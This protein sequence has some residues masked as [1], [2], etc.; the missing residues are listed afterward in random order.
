MDTSRIHLD[1][2]GPSLFFFLLQTLLKGRKE[3]NLERTSS[4]YATI[5]S[6]KHTLKALK[7]FLHRDSAK[8]SILIITFNKNYLSLLKNN[9]V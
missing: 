2:H 9:Y 7:H 6:L 8:K 1:A 5:Y 3:M 4:D